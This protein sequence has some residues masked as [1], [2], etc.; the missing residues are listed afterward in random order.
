MRDDEDQIQQEN[1]LKPRPIPH[2]ES[3]PD[4]MMPSPGPKIGEDHQDN[5]YISDWTAA[6]GR[7][8]APAV[9][10][11]VASMWKSW[12][13]KV[14]QEDTTSPV[15][16]QDQIDEAKKAVGNF[17][18]P[19]GA[20]E[21][22]LQYLKKDQLSKAVNESLLSVAKP[23]FL[24]AAAQAAG[25]LLGTFITDPA[26]TV[27][28]AGVGAAISAIAGPEILL[29]AAAVEASEIIPILVQETGSLT[30]ALLRF[31]G[32]KSLQV[33]SEFAAFQES[34]EIGKKTLQ[35][36]LDQ[37]YDAFQGL[38]NIAESGVFGGVAGPV[39]A[40]AFK[41]FNPEFR[42]LFSNALH[43]T[44][45]ES[46]SSKINQSLKDSGV[47]RKSRES[48][49]DRYKAELNTKAFGGRQ[50]EDAAQTVLNQMANGKDPD[51]S[52]P[53]RQGIA[54]SAKAFKDRM[55]ADG[56]DLDDA[57]N[58]LLA[59]RREIEAKH[60]PIADE[61]DRQDDL[62]D[63][64]NLN[65]S[66]LKLRSDELKRL[67]KF[68]ELKLSRDESIKLKVKE[69]TLN[70]EIHRISAS[71]KKITQEVTREKPRARREDK[72]RL[73]RQIIQKR[74]KPLQDEA[75]NVRTAL[76]RFDQFKD[77]QKRVKQIDN[78][79]RPFLKEAFNGP[80]SIDKYLNSWQ[81]LFNKHMDFEQLKAST[82][83]FQ[84]FIDTNETEIPNQA[85]NDFI[86]DF[87]S[88]DSDFSKTGGHEE[89]KEPGRDFENPNNLLSDT[90][91]ESRKKEILPDENLLSKEE[92]VDFE[93]VKSKGERLKLFRDAF[94][95]VLIP[96]LLGG[97]GD[98]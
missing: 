69:K 39:G 60:K 79:V 75:D 4:M 96:C 50:D 44:S 95:K 92:K 33:G 2:F 87:D 84:H 34:Q 94:T 54:L 6:L 15:A 31:A 71:T 9:D 1:E 19:D 46:V 28:A 80:V 52:M 65:I 90:Y 22:T 76:D 93:R 98:A 13:I 12:R 18:V 66:K 3:V 91:P 14:N 45:E 70:D 68:D 88:P 38:I 78:E 35:T 55:A 47:S 86:K 7:F 63:K 89:L 48:F 41:G 17:D 24:S 56:I 37:D 74:M 23:G 16:T 73:V 21:T 61:M 42:K 5:V 81:D 62:L 10:S 26:A 11:T 32:F 53:Y 57:S 43:G 64:H 77:A 49:S 83:L 51:P 59:A 72:A 82:G 40:L 20:R 36:S 85:V 29:G 27:A 8:K 67:A 58:A 97:G 30:N 25:S